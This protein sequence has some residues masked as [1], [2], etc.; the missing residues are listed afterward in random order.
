MSR[1]NG[2]GD[3]HEQVMRMERRMKQ[4]LV[5]SILTSMAKKRRW[6]IAM[7]GES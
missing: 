3:G 2:H 5:A 7:I 6:F 4:T 1:L